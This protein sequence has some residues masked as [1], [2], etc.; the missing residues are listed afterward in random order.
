MSEAANEFNLVFPRLGG[1][2]VISGDVIRK[3][4]AH[5]PY[6]Q[7][8]WNSFCVGTKE[9]S[10]IPEYGHPD[11]VF[12]F[13]DEYGEIISFYEV[14]YAPAGSTIHMDVLKTYALDFKFRDPEHV[15]H[16]FVV[17][18]T[19]LPFMLESILEKGYCTAPNHLR[20]VFRGNRMLPEFSVLHAGN[21]VY[22]AMLQADK[23]F[24]T[25]CL[26]PASF[27][28]SSASGAGAPPENTPQQ[29]A[30]MRREASLKKRQDEEKRERYHE[31]IR[32]NA[33]AARVRREAGELDLRR[34]E[35]AEIYELRMAES[36]RRHAAVMAA[37]AAAAEEA[38]AAGAARSTITG[39]GAKR[40]LEAST[41]ISE[42]AADVFTG[43][44]N[45]LA[46]AYGIAGLPKAPKYS[47]Y[48]YFETGVRP[49]VDADD[50]EQQVYVTS[51]NVLLTKLK[52]MGYHLDEAATKYLGGY[53][54]RRRTPSRKPR[55][56][57]S[58]K[59]KSRK[60]KRSASKRR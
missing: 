37:V 58:R 35:E 16:T 53:K 10:M 31:E 38:E 17:K 36:D 39:A 34:R 49:K 18:S 7:D 6:L 50:I 46:E 45:V 54:R 59:P 21:L 11:F 14:I 2:V 57:R 33:N 3:D 4:A 13:S 24:L 26:P 22:L 15:Y 28:G 47:R 55:R 9:E 48:S 5:F 25:A 44:Y 60:L 8:L 51:L 1:S 41:V 56:S 20:L 23:P 32:I 43:T 30:K 40:V 19:Q 42:E 12:A 27:T 29:V 52:N